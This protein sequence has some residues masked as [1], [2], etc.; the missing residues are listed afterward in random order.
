MAYRAK[1]RSKSDWQRDDCIGLWT[2]CRN[3][4]VEEAVYGRAAVRCCRRERCVLFAIQLAVDQGG[5][6]WFPLQTG[7]VREAG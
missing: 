6:N 4:S 5:G 7:F 3:G 1:L 2:G